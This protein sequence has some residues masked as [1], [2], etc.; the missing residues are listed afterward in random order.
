VIHIYKYSDLNIALDVYSGAVHTVSEAAYGILSY[1]ELVQAA[2]GN[3]M[4]SEREGADIFAEA[5]E[6]L[7]GKFE[8]SELD[9]AAEELRELAEKGLLQSGPPEGFAA[10]PENRGAVIKA[11]CLH[12]AHDCNM[13]CAYC[14]AEAGGYSGEKSLLPY[15]T[16]KAAIDFLLG[17]SGQRRNLE[18]DF[19]GGEP[20]MN[21]DAVRQIVLYAR[22][23]EKKPGKNIRFTITTNGLLLDDEARAFINEHFYNAVISL[24]GR[25]ETNDRVRKTPDGGG[26]YDLI[27]DNL[28]EF[29]RSRDIDNKLYYVRGTYTSWNK[30]FAKDVKHLA[31][32]GF[33]NI[34]MEPV[35]SDLSLPYSLSEKDL[36]ELYEEY[37]RLA[38]LCEE[39]GQDGKPFEF[40]H[41]KVDL[42]QG[43]CIFKRVAGCGAGTEYIAVTPSGDIYPCHRFAGDAKF[44]LGNVHDEI[45]ENP[46]YGLFNEAHV[47]S[48]PKCRGCW[49]KYYCSGGCHA[50]AYFENGSIS[51]PHL[52]SCELEKK[53]LELAIGIS[54][55]DLLMDRPA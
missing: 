36:P 35:V 9:E 1:V 40:F 26:T 42:S 13:R 32:L 19:F 11:M 20:L 55:S 49:A 16:G 37:D 41:F 21:F 18:V 52:L 7:S 3:T 51:E 5:I 45:F 4:G 46:M 14:F 6:K 30:D 2:P 47:E 54:V 12:A 44:L 31:E 23:A 29:A 53:R 48:K 33:K 25:R 38:R 27:L 15:E 28:L 24:D 17:H 50:N 43:P 10:S 39:T 8:K 34:S 22:E